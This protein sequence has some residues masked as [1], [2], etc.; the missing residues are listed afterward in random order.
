MAPQPAGPSFHVSIG[1]AMLRLRDR[2]YRMLMGVQDDAA[3]IDAS[4]TVPIREIFRRFWP[5]TQPYRRWILLALVFT[6]LGPAI[7]TASIWLFKV[8]VDGVLVPHDFG[9]FFRIALAY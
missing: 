7:E 2:I 8:L 1:E 9:P 5:L 6:V 3:L 4:P